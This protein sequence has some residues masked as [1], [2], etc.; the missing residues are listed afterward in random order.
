MSTK[1]IQEQIVSNMRRWQKVENGSVASTG[2]IM[3]KTNNPLV[4]LVMEIIQRDSQFHYRVQEFISDTLE[5]K[6]VSLT[7]DELGEVWDMIERHIEIEEKTV[8]LAEE[9]LGAIKGKKM[10]VVEYLLNYLLED[11]KKHNL[12]LA[13]LAKIKDGMYPY[14]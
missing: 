2:R 1:E 14:A 8:E 10:L 4:R 11:E 3:E 9:A 13:H 12:I 6:P 5:K 7:P